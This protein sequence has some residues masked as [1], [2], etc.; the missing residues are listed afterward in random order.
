MA[1]W[2]KM[3]TAALGRIQV[4][5]AEKK[6]KENKMFLDFTVDSTSKMPGGINHLAMGGEGSRG[7][8]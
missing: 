4:K 8:A 5:N 7:C 3:A 1:K 2:G 6:M